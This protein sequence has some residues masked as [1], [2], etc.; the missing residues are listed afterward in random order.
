MYRTLLIF[1]FVTLTVFNAHA[2]EIT[3]TTEDGFELPATLL[4]PAKSNGAGIILIHQGGSNRGEWVFMHDQLLSA[5]Y[6]LLSYDIRGMGDAPKVSANGKKVENIYNAP[7][8]AP[9]DLKAAIRRLKAV[10]NV[11]GTRLGIVGASVG[12]NLAA[13]G[14]ATMGIKSAVSISGKTEAVQNLAG[15]KDIKMKSVYYISSMESGGARA[16]WAEEMYNLTD[17][18]REMSISPNENGHGVTILQDMPS[19][20]D[21]IM[22][23]LERNL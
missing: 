2:E 20:Q 23:W 11:D 6:V 13:V 10:P 3:L 4:T 17:S 21:Q 18:P 15:Q 16:R 12:G 1:V 7:D 9:L 19:L 14:S 5:G 8:Q 22:R